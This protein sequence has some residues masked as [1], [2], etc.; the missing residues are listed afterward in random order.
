[1]RA[2]CMNRRV[3]REFVYCP[4]PNRGDICGETNKKAF[5]LKMK[6]FFN[7]IFYLLILISSA[8]SD[9]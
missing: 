7:S 6:R 3:P 1:M 9:Q 5:H 2:A 8:D 4:N